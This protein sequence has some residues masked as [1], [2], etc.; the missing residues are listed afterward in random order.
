V[1]FCEHGDELW[2]PT[3]LLQILT[4]ICLGERYCPTGPAVHLRNSSAKEKVRPLPTNCQTA[5]TIIFVTDSKKQSPSWEPG[6][7]SAI[8][9]IPRILRNRMFITA[10]T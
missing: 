6:G 10:F 2:G 9:E 8:P 3:C 5:G 1:G 7:F 4:F